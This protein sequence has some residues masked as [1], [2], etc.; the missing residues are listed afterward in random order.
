MTQTKPN[1]GQ[2]MLKLPNCMIN[3]TIFNIF[4]ASW[5]QFLSYFCFC[6]CKWISQTVLFFNKN[7]IKYSSILNFTFA[8]ARLIK[9]KKYNCTHLPTQHILNKKYVGI[10][11]CWKSFLCCNCRF[12]NCESHSCIEKT[13][14]ALTQSLRISM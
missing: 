6:I 1:A 10:F 9:K 5:F 11:Q 12:L 14:H 4:L 13:S 8:N 7:Q 2:Y 3:D